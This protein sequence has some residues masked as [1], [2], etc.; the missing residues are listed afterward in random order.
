M[1]IDLRGLAAA[2]TQQL[3]DISQVRSLLQQMRGKG[4]PQHMWGDPLAQTS[5][6][7]RT[8]QNHC[9]TR[10]TVSIPPQALKQIL[11][12]LVA[13]IVLAQIVKKLV[14]QKRVTILIAL[15]IPHPQ[16]MPVRFNILD[17]QI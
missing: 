12:R 5:L 14:R 17:F 1:R 10:R 8:R 4:M 3:L 9:H 13:S 15:A 6:R 16:Q 2:M 11:L 7:C